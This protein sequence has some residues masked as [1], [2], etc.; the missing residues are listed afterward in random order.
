MSVSYF[1]RIR[2][3][4]RSLRGQ[5]W[6]EGNERFRG[7]RRHHLVAYFFFF[8]SASSTFSLLL[9]VYFS[10]YASP[11][12]VH[13]YAAYVPF[14]GLRFLQHTVR[15]QNIYFEVRNFLIFSDVLRIEL[16][17]SFEIVFTLGQCS[18]KS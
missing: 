11:P 4:S 12:Y 7:G 8:G 1:E 18:K 2:E 5:R 10:T 15:R 9:S 13:F 14:S 6:L 17:L 16:S 3:P